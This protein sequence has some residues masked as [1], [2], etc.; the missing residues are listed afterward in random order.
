M[1]QKLRVVGIGCDGYEG[2]SARAVEALSSARRIIGSPRQ[3]RLLA[4]VDLDA[5]LSP[6]PSGFWKDWQATLAG[7]DPAVDVILASGDPMF[8]GVGASLVREL[9]RGGVEVIPAPSSASL[10]CAYLGWP[11][12]D[13]PVISLV[14]GEPGLPGAARVVPVA[15][16]LRPFLVLCRNADSVQE[17]ATVL[18]DRPD[19]K[20][21]ALTNLGGSEA[22]GLL[23]S[24]AEGTV[25]NP[26]VPAGNLTVLAVEPSGSARGWLRDGDFDS[27]GQ[28]T[29]APIRQMTVAAL[30]PRPGALLWDV[31]GGTGSIG[32]EWAR[33]GGHTEIFERDAVRAERIAEN[34]ANL[35]GNVTVHHGA[36]PG[37]L[38]D[39]NL[40]PDAI[41]IGGGLTADG[42]LEACWQRLAPGGTIVANTVTL[43]SEALLWQA[44]RDYGGDVTRLSVE[45][46]G[47]VG[48][49]TAWRPALPVVQWV[50]V[51]PVEPA[52]P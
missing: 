32:I 8:H 35:S 13:T 47:A 6:W 21:T 34:V 42:M 1:S 17:V 22:T 18:A 43:E 19:T 44:R 26:P 28:L 5:E 33:H 45:R 38:A 31:G 46:A 52:L 40:R 23:E 12:H 14:T 4:D 41:F 16:S 30:D 2:L 37:A 20:L 11:L 39:S 9:G 29:K 3:L 25:A 49:F 24:V 51:K 36:A 7:I 48:T 10:A 50:A 15:D 27:D